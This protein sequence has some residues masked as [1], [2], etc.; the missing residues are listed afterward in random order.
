M[1]DE[2]IRQNVKR[3][4]VTT[5]DNL[6]VKC[7]Q[8][9]IDRP[10]SMRLCS[11]CRLGE[12]VDASPGLKNRPRAPER[13][14]TGRPARAVRRPVERAPRSP[15]VKIAFTDEQLARARDLYEGKGQRLKDVAQALGVGPNVA[16][17][18]LLAAG[19]RIRAK[20]ERWLPDE[21]IARRYRDGASL[22]RLARDF[23]TSPGTIRNHLERLGVDVDHCPQE[24]A[25]LDAAQLAREYEAGASI[26]D[27]RRKYGCGTATVANRLRAAGVTIRPP[28]RHRA[29]R[30]AA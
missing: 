9:K 19:V 3:A 13:I 4:A 26:D 16:R 18:E 22:D 7:A 6:C 11:W 8:G 15:R 24:R 1:N 27:L 29:R 30:A 25:D 28:G 10:R 21:E 5:S 23:E 14:E 20:R 2:E 17:R 12:V